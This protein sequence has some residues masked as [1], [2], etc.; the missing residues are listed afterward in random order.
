MDRLPYEVTSAILDHVDHLQDMHECTLVNKRFYNIM[1]PLLWYAPARTS[2]FEDVNPENAYTLAK[3]LHAAHDHPSG[4]LHARSLGQYVRRLSFDSR[5]TPHHI[6]IVLEHTPYLE[7]L[8]LANEEI[9][10]I[11]I[12]WIFRHCPGLFTLSLRH[13]PLITDEAMGSLAQHCRMVDD[14]TLEDCL[15]LTSDAL[16][17]L[18][19]MGIQR[20][21][22]RDCDTW[23]TRPKT[24]LLLRLFDHQLTDLCIFH[25]K[26][27]TPA[28][29][30]TFLRCLSPLGPKN[31]QVPLPRLECF[32]MAKGRTDPPLDNSVLIPFFKSHPH[33]A[34]FQLNEAVVNEDTFKA[35]GEYLPELNQLELSLVDGLSSQVIRNLVKACPKLNWVGL[36]HCELPRRCFPEV[37]TKG[38]LVDHLGKR[39]TRLIRLDK[40][41]LVFKPEDDELTM[42]EEEEA[43]AMNVVQEDESDFDE[44]W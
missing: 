26:A 12:D 14:L 41:K 13:L 32:Y 5:D 9:D 20:L 16:L 38:R 4:F 1:N 27:H 31:P 17:P 42:S 11:S 40:D 19:D 7:E 29:N 8:T 39:S 37:R 44:F 43:A 2:M 35:M 21:Q 18:H 22:I 34:K 6:F 23:G 25:T 15:G 28:I 24:A 30:A 33:L 3:C 36:T 10:D